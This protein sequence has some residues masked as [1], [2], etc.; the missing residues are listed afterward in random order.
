LIRLP[1]YFPHTIT[2]S[3][4]FYNSFH[5]NMTRRQLHPLVEP[6]DIGT[7]KVSDIHT[8]YYEQSGNPNGKPVVVLHGGPGFEF[9]R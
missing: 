7:L 4:R 3:T 1:K 8:L 6:Y 5:Q 2:V 9:L